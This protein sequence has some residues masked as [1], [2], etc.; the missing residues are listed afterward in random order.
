MVNGNKTSR[1][2]NQQDLKNVWMQWEKETGK[3]NP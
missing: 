1:R 2:L 3:E